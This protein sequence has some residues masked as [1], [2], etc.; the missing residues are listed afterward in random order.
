MPF[1]RTPDERFNNL[2]DYP[3]APHYLDVEGLR[4]HYVDEA[5][6]TGETVLM[7][8][9]EPSWS[10]LYR[11]M[12]P[13][14]NAAGHRCVAPDLIGFGK[15]DKPT[16]RNDY[17]YQ[18]HLNWLSDFIEQLDLTNVTLF[19]QDWGGLLGLKLLT[20][21]PER[22]VR[23]VAANT[24]LPTGDTPANDSFNEWKQFSQHSPKFNI[25]KVIDM[26]TVAPVSEEV[27]AAYN[28]PF[29]DESYKAGARQFP[30]L[31]PVTPDDP[32]AQPNREAW[33]ILQQFDKPFLTA[34]SDKD[35]I[36]SGLDGIFQSMIPGAKDQAH[37][38]IVN[39]G[40]F[41]Q[42]EKGEELALVVNEFITANP[43]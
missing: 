7:L 5:G 35:P 24:F 16:D 30:S 32:A 40:H 28:A 21:M 18:T 15:S 11:T 39:A 31:V 26:A 38:T 23:V 1:V 3:F 10:Y 43:V 9:G 4:M 36:M 37:T 12:I 20:D 42:E 33:G 6:S 2:P 29:P 22:F 14:I 8:H 27:M 41:L 19:C 25:G 13:G 17:S 34:F